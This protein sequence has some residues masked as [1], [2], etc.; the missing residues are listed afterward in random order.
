MRRGN[1]TLAIPVSV[2]LC[3]MKLESRE[4]RMWKFWGQTHTSVR[5]QNSRLRSGRRTFTGKAADSRARSDIP[6]QIRKFTGESGITGLGRAFPGKV[7]NSRARSAIPGQVWKFPGELGNSR[8]S[9]GIPG[10]G[11]EFPGK[12]GN[13][14]TRSGM[15]GQGRAC[16]RRSG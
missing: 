10:Q 6:G 16:R 13:S 15:P 1:L 14:R 3:E 5:R 11:R 7:G 2:P 4:I 9:S 12:V 8:A